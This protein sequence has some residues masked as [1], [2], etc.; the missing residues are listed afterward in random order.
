MECQ[1][2]EE[3]YLELRSAALDAELNKAA[4]GLPPPT[5]STKAAARYLGVHFDTL[6]DW[7]RR[8]PPAGPP[9][10]KGA[11]RA[12]G[13]ANEHVRYPYTELVAWQASRVGRSVKERRLID[14]LDAAQQ[15]VRELEIELALRQARDDAS[16][17]QKKLGRI[18]TLATL[19]DIA[20]VPHEWALVDGRVAGHVL[21]VS[22]DVLS[23]ALERGDVWDAT[24]EVALQAPWVDGETREPYHAAYAN[25]LQ[26]VMQ[27]LREAKAAQQAS[28]LEARW[29]PGAV[30]G[31]SA[32]PF[33]RHTEAS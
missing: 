19:D 20:V 3:D 4:A 12:G 22:D 9:F 33:A 2:K 7:R 10:V 26:I 15:R 29:A 28:D 6:G 21:V 27:E 14:E 30:S 8:T 32:R 24:I 18:A 31:N 5:I 16:R 13:G 11:G 17:L 25:V 1:R 23:G